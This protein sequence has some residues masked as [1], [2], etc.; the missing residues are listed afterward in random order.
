MKT[1]RHSERPCRPRPSDEPERGISLNPYA[2]TSRK[3]RHC[4]IVHH[5]R[6]EAVGPS[7]DHIDG[8][9]E[10]ELDAKRREDPLYGIGRQ[11]AKRSARMPLVPH[12]S[13][14]PLAASLHTPAPTDHDRLR[15]ARLRREAAEHERTQRL[16]AA[17]GRLATPTLVDTDRQGYSDQFHPEF[18][19]AAAK[20]RRH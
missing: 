3:Q 7:R 17:R 10:L 8:G 12:A 11:L 6:S 14:Q 5:H 18:T 19:R 16:L 2:G 1:V 13:P 20:R 9:I 4:T 15:Q